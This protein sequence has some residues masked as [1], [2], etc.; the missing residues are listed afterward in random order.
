LTNILWIVIDALRAD[1]LGCYGF[2]RPTT[3]NIERLAGSGVRFAEMISP[4]IPTHPAHTALFSGRDVFDLRIVAQGGRVKPPDGIR[5]LRAILRDHGYFTA[6]VDNI[7][8]WIAP[9][10]ERYEAT[11]RWDHDGSSPWRNGEDVTAMG[12][13]LLDEAESRRRPYFLFLHYWD[14]HTPYLPP[15]LFDRMN[16]LPRGIPGHYNKPASTENK[17]AARWGAGGPRSSR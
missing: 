16:R 11:A 12:L 3:S 17:Q 8:L 14:P 6:A 15:T 2:G 13:H 10:F 7:K 4:H 5:F 1:R 9:Q